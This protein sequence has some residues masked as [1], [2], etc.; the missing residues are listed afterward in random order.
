MPPRAGR[1][2]FSFD[3]AIKTLGVTPERLEKLIA[4]GKIA[5]V[6]D[7]PHRY[8]PRRAILA[9]LAEVSAVPIRQRQR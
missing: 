7:G 3:E 9:Y 2:D 5:T 8:I 6:S 4:E 1:T